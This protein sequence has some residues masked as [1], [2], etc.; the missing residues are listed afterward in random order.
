MIAFILVFWYVRKIFVIFRKNY[1]MSGK[2]FYVREDNDMSGKFFE[3][4]SPRRQH[5]WE[6]FFRCPFLSKSASRNSPP[7]NFLMLPTPLVD[8]PLV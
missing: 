7:P 1:D 4:T 5:F 6:K 3:L 2:I 8:P